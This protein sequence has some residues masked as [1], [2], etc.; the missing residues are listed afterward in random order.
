MLRVRGEYLSDSVSTSAPCASPASL[1]VPTSR[2]QERLGRGLSCHLQPQMTGPRLSLDMSDQPGRK[3]FL[4]QEGQAPLQEPCLLPR[5]TLPAHCCLTLPSQRGHCRRSH[6]TRFLGR[7]CKRHPNPVSWPE[8]GVPWA[9][10]H[11][12]CPPHSPTTAH[13]AGHT[14]PVHAQSHNKPV[15]SCVL[16]APPCSAQGCRDLRHMAGRVS[17]FP[18][19][20]RPGGPRE[21]DM[22]GSW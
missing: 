7:A 5:V 10:P 17:W 9:L 14:G 11:R 1:P 20:D 18:R 2:I 3:D 22:Q 19:A 21:G 15:S 16:S 12:P 6:S 8:P 4:L 13:G